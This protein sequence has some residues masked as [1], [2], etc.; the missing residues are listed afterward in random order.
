MLAM[1][2]SCLL[3]KRPRAA[4]IEIY[5]QDLW[6]CAENILLPLSDLNSTDRQ[7]VLFPSRSCLFFIAPQAIL[8]P[9]DFLDNSIE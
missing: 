1:N 7:E 9:S 2:T 8:K 3:F 4:G 6:I 5:L